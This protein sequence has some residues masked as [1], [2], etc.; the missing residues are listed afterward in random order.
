MGQKVNPKAMR[1]GINNTWSSKWFAPRRKYATYFLQ[2]LKVRE[3]LEKTYPHAG[4]AEV[5][6]LRQSNQVTV[7]IYSSKPGL[8][9][10]KGGEGMEDLKSK[11]YRKFDTKFDVNVLEVKQTYKY[12][13]LVAENITHQVERRLP[14]RRVVKAAL[15]KAKEEGVQGIKVTVAGRLN[16]V[17]IARSETF[18]EGTIPLHTFRAD[19]DYFPGR[20]N[21][22]YGVIGIKVWVYKGEVFKKPES[23]ELNS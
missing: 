6:V 21:T 20:A 22:T 8:I 10:G 1:I 5:E 2:D 16:G 17:E 9:I 14:Y 4:I 12:A 19:I 13:K 3:Y 7:N 23:K 15:A 11:L 18:A